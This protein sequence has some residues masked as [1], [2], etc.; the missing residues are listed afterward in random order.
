MQ[1]E[2]GQCTIT[3]E[4]LGTMYNNARGFGDKARETDCSRL[5]PGGSGHVLGIAHR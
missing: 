4:D 5:R 1:E 3:R 2:V